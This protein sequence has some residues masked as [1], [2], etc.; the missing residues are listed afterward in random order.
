MD[1]SNIPMHAMIFRCGWETN[2]LHTIFSYVF[3]SKLNGMRCGKNLSNLFYKVSS[4]IYGGVPPTL[5]DIQTES[6]MVHLF[7][8]SIFVHRTGL[9]YRKKLKHILAASILQFY[10]A[11]IGIIG[12]EP[13]GKYKDISHHPF[14]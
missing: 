4:E 12:N 10:D 2:I 3:T 8:N 9:R 11:F 13:S 5:D 14:H 6:Q 7:V 1:E